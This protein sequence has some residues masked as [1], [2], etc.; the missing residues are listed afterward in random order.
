MKIPDS[1]CKTA[2]QFYEY[3]S[4]NENSNKRETFLGNQGLTALNLNMWPTFFS[5]ELILEI[6]TMCSD[7]LELI[8]SIPKRIFDN[9][10]KRISEYYKLSESFLSQMD[11]VNFQSDLIVGRGDFVMAEDGFKCVEYNIASNLGGWEA[12]YIEA[13]YKNESYIS[14]FF[15][16]HGPTVEIKDSLYICLKH[17]LSF[18]KNSDLFNND[19]KSVNVVLLDPAGESDHSAN[20][21][22]QDVYKN[23]VRELFGTLPGKIQIATVG[24]LNVNQESLYLGNDR[25]EILIDMSHL[26]TEEIL[27]LMYKKKLIVLNGPIS[28]LLNNKLNLAL[29]SEHSTSPLFSK[30]EQDTIN[31]YIPWSRK[32]TKTFKNTDGEETSTINYLNQFKDEFVIKRSDGFGGK[33]VFIGKNSTSDEWNDA[34]SEALQEENWIMQKFYKSKEYH[35]QK[36]EL[37]YDLHDAIWGFFMFG[38]TYGGGFARLMP[39][40]HE[41]GVINSANGATES[42]IFEEI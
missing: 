5:K 4:T 9:D 23:V 10:I 30:E 16:M 28:Y 41:R 40:S 20:I 36:G 6:E 32:I 39:S 37:G 7:I 3:I 34:I 19:T 29:L 25:V 11:I 17:V 27:N 1:T 8:K 15:L 38:K 2:Q 35:Y 33:D 12:K 24:N 22:V 13:L 18:Y 14:E 31:K 26:L 42:F 21:F